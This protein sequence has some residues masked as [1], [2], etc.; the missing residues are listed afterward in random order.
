MTKYALINKHLKSAFSLPYSLKHIF[1]RLFSTDSLPV[2]TLFSRFS[3]SLWLLCLLLAGAFSPLHAQSGDFDG[4]VKEEGDTPPTEYKLTIETDVLTSG[5]DV[6]ITVSGKEIEGS[7]PSYTVK[8]GTEVTVSLPESLP[9]G[10]TLISL[11]GTSASGN[12]FLN[13]LEENLPT[14]FSFKMP[15]TNITLH[16]GFKVVEQPDPEPEPE[17]EPDPDPTPDPDPDPVVYHTVTLPEVEG[18][19]TNPAAG[20]YL[21]AHNSSFSFYLTLKEGY[22]QSVPVVGTNLGETLTPDS[23]GRYRIYPV[24]RNVIV[25]IDGIRPDLPPVANERI[26]APDAVRIRTS[27]GQLQ[28]SSKSASSLYIYN[29]GGSLLHTFP[30]EAGGQTFTL[31]RGTYFLRIGGNSYKVIL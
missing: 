17:P 15:A 5:K 28:I 30:L 1:F 4:E 10:V 23:Q 31:P 9:E 24:R 14:T 11:S 3:G 21:V 20:E 18:V 7:A 8:T 12:W 6:T 29:I 2:G 25:S 19:T 22:T 16:F 26:D 27:Q 13:P